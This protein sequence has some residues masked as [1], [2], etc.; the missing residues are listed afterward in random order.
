[1]KMLY[2]AHRSSAFAISSFI[3]RRSLNTGT[4]EQCIQAGIASII[5]VDAAY[6]YI[7][8]TF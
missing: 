8:L 3:D 6:L 7:I 2:Y 4:I 5:A 1:M